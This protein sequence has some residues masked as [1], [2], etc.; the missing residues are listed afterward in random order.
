MAVRLTG[1][2]PSSAICSSLHRRPHPQQVLAEDLADGCLVV[3][4]RLHA[5][6]QV[7]IVGDRLQFLRQFATDAVEVG[8]AADVGGVGGR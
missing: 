7:R 1:I 4:A 6:D 2:V 5:G 3:A 8:A